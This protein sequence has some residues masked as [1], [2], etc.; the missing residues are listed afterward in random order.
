MKAAGVLAPEGKPPR[1][2][3]TRLM[4][5][6]LVQELDS[7][8]PENACMVAL[9]C[10]AFWSQSRLGELVS[11]RA[12]SFDDKRTL[13]RAHLGPS[14]TRSGSR[15]INYPWTKT[16]GLKGDSTILNRQPGLVDPIAA[17]ENHLSINNPILNLPLFSFK[18]D[19]RQ[20]CMTKTRFLGICNGV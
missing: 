20:M 2:P 18:V 9:A 7:S 8:I 1:P 11:P 15:T 3:V 4:L 12:N 5:E 13:K 10:T 16:R 17:L 14:V 19:T 6:K